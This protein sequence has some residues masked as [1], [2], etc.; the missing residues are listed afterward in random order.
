METNKEETPPLSIHD[1]RRRILE[2]VKTDKMVAM[3]INAASEDGQKKLTKVKRSLSPNPVSNRRVHSKSPQR[4][5]STS[6]VVMEGSPRKKNKKPVK[7]A[8]PVSGGKHPKPQ[9]VS[10]CRCLV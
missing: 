2:K 10:L 3:G 9:E 7:G 8:V 5:R 1:K 6:P 4:P